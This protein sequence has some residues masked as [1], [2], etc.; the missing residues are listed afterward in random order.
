MYPSPRPFILR[1]A[2]AGL[3]AAMF[4]SCS[5]PSSRSAADQMAVR[6][7][8]F[9]EAPQLK[10]LAER[11]RQ[12]GNTMY[13]EVC[14]LLG[15][16]GEDFPRHFDVEFKRRLPK[17]NAADAPIGR[18]RLN[19][20]YAD[21]FRR[22][23]GQF[24][25]VVIH[26]LTHVAQRYW[27]P[28]VGRWLSYSHDPPTY[29]VEGIA[30]YVSFKLGGTNGWRCAHCDF[31]YPDYRNGYSCA[32]AF[33]LHLER[34]YNSNIVRQLN[35]RLRHGGYS[36][37]F[38]LNATGKELPE[39]WAEFRQTPAFTPDAARMLELQQALGYVNGKPPKHLA[40][41]LD[42]LAEQRTDAFTRD[43][44]KSARIWG[45]KVPD[46][47][48]RMALY[49][50][51]TQ[52]GGSAEAFLV[53]LKKDGKVPG[54]VEGEKGT[55]SGFLSASNLTTSYPVT[56]SF[57]AT[58][59]GNSSLYHYEVARASAGGEWHLQR[60]WRTDPEGVI[61]EEFSVR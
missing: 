12:V 60:A 30:D 35:T 31:L 17:G 9:R 8:C 6:H 54:F 41:R 3:V 53:Q 46:L 33:L 18:I 5:T 47:Q 59:Q 21:E 15:D 45:Q 37:A 20:Q 22:K 61:A 4:C 36:E 49:L 13:P 48:G 26:E 16:G 27:Q 19:A 25:Q 50:Y 11:A 44:L 56:R 14:A 39:L 28:I 2:L 57:T 7:V 40:Q 43:L 23:A 55:L 38:F 58:K 52:P 1:T 29:W 34:T 32:G 24:E 51:F 42:T 10:D